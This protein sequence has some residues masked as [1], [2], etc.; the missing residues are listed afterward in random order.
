MVAEGAKR[1]RTRVFFVVFVGHNPSNR[2]QNETNALRVVK[3]AMEAAKEQSHCRLC[4]FTLAIPQLVK[5]G[6]GSADTSSPQAMIITPL[7][8]HPQRRTTNVGR[9]LFR[10]AYI[11][12]NQ[13]G[14]LPLQLPFC[15]PIHS[16]A[17]SRII[18]E[19]FNRHGRQSTWSRRYPP[20][21]K[22]I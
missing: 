13:S 15:N 17:L 21:G 14:C 8:R 16:Q 7:S 22:P 18:H 10:I 12:P 5:F 2:K 1:S 6:T 9:A 3:D 11:P 19:A 20:G 4:S